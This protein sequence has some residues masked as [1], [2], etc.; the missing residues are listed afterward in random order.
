MEPELF[1]HDEIPSTSRLT[2]ADRCDVRNCGAQA[3]VTV[4]MWPDTGGPVEL[5]FCGHHFT[6]HEARL[7]L[8]ATHIF[9]E[10]ARLATTETSRKDF[11]VG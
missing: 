10:R 2:S 5:I 9:D 1:T 11:Y 8:V 6:H 3:Y 4:G 7:R